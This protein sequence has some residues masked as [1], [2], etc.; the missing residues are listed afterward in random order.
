MIVPYVPKRTCHFQPVDLLLVPRI[1]K[2]RMGGRSFSYQLSPILVSEADTP[3]TFKARLKTF[4]FD[5]A[6]S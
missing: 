1:S 2:N 4:L 6:Y 5:K 3:S